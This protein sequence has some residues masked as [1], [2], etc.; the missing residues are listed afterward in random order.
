M[1]AQNLAPEGLSPSGFA[2]NRMKP[3][4]R[5]EL[6]QLE[7][8]IADLEAENA[9]LRDAALTF[10]GL[11]ERLNEQ[12]RAERRRA[13]EGGAGRQSS[14]DPWTFALKAR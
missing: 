6:R 2:T 12:L 10:G 4:T 14:S 1:D 7:Q 8:R 5:T 3:R 9:H 11:A 13:I